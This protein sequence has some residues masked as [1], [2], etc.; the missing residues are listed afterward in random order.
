ML[1]NYILNVE[2]KNEQKNISITNISTCLVTIDAK[3]QS[4]E[5]AR[6]QAWP[7]T[8]LLMIQEFIQ[9]NNAL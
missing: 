7:R 8:L 1:T 9:K 2:K 3:K 4:R 5:P 6:L